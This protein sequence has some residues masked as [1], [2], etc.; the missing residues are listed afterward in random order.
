MCNNKERYT[1]TLKGCTW[2][3]HITNLQPIDEGFYSCYIFKLQPVVQLEDSNVARLVVG[4]IGTTVTPSQIEG[5]VDQNAKF[6][7]QTRPIIDSGLT[8]KWYIKSTYYNNHD[9]SWRELMAED[10]LT[11]F[12]DNNKTLTMERLTMRD[13]GTAVKC[14]VFSGATSATGNTTSGVLLVH[15][16]EVTTD[17]VSTSQMAVT[18]SHPPTRY[19]A[20]SSTDSVPRDR[21]YRQSTTSA[22][23]TPSTLPT[24]KQDPDPD[25]KNPS[26]GSTDSTVILV[27]WPLAAV[28]IL[29]LIASLLYIIVTK[30]RSKANPNSTRDSSNSSR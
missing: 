26:S 28:A 15:R 8:Y 16:D 10:R 4:P 13:N 27:G 2:T 20:I 12:R 6:R 30:R 1:I 14:M 18:T 3:F 25:S 22:P 24:K 29:L 21:P 11:A 7:C 5:K 23:D 19:P 17:E 9:G